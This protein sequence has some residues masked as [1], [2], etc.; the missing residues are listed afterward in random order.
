MVMQWHQWV[1]GGKTQFYPRAMCTKLG[2]AMLRASA[3]STV[4]LHGS[5]QTTRISNSQCRHLV[6]RQVAIIVRGSI[7]SKNRLDRKCSPTWL[8][9]NRCKDSIF[10]RMPPATNSTMKCHRQCLP[11]RPLFQNRTRCQGA[12][13]LKM[14]YDQREIYGLGAAKIATHSTLVRSPPAPTPPSSSTEMQMA[15]RSTSAAAMSRRRRRP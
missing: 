3:V 14:W 6:I 12:S 5:G 10:A 1:A 9:K 8:C 15:R 13:L 7:G 11:R 2:G 4:E